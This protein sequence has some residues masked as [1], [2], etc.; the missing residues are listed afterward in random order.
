MV[1]R[2]AINITD[3]KDLF[4][5]AN[6]VSGGIYYDLLLVSFWMVLFMW[7]KGKNYP[8]GDSFVASSFLTMI[9]GT[10]LFM[11]EAVTGERLTVAIVVFVVSA[12]YS[13]WWEREK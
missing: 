13:Y 6:Y 8:T 4:D 9:L 3:V 11:W 10:F 12:L 2:N 5:Y 7:F 1:Y